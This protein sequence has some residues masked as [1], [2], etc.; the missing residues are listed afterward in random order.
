MCNKLASEF[1]PQTPMN[2]DFDKHFDELIEITFPQDYIEEKLNL[3]Y[4]INYLKYNVDWAKI[5]WRLSPFQLKHYYNREKLLQD[6]GLSEE[7][8]YSHKHLQEAINSLELNPKPTF[9]MIMILYYYFIKKRSTLKWSTAELLE[10]IVEHIKKSKIEEVTV[11][12][13]VGNKH[14]KFSDR[15][16]IYKIIE[17]NREQKN[18]APYP[19]YV[20]MH[21]MHNN[22]GYMHNIREL[23]YF[24]IK[25]LLDYLPIKTKR[26]KGSRFSQ[27]ERKFALSVL[28][29]CGRIDDK[30]NVDYVCS[31]E[32]NVTFDKLIRDYKDINP[33]FA[34]DLYF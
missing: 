24:L 28:H 14:Y 29:F 1:N 2:E 23:D 21:T 3:K 27:A 16:F 19:P 32:N 5:N 34:L 31:N 25:T 11:D 22:P 30:G 10:R 8:Y 9:V 33:P 18:N 15:D 20:A 26:R 4:V 7:K 12:I 17:Y 13:K 6:T